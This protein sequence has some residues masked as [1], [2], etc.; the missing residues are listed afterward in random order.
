MGI[1]LCSGRGTGKSRALARSIAWQDWLS[2]VPVVIIDG[3]GRCCEE[4]IDRLLYL[5]PEY[6]VSLAKRIRYVDCSGQSGYVT[7]T[8]LWYRIGSESLREVSQRF[9]ALILKTDPSLI[10]ASVEGF[11]ALNRIATYTGMVLFAMGCQ[12]TEAD[13]FLRN[14]EAWSSH[15]PEAVRTYP[16]VAPAVE[17]FTQ[18]YREMQPRSRE[19]LTEAFRNKIFALSLDPA[20]QALFGAAAPGIDWP[21]VVAERQAVLLDF[22]RA[23]S[24]MQQLFMLWWFDYLYAYIKQRGPGKNNVPLSFLIDELVLLTNPK[25]TGVNPFEADLDELIQVYS[26]NASVWL[27]VAHQEYHQLN[28][29]LRHTMASLGTQV[30]GRVSDID[31]ALALAKEL[32]KADPWKVKW[33]ENVWASDSTNRLETLHFV[34]DS[35]AVNMSIDEQILLQAYALKELN[36]FE[37]LVRPATVEGGVSRKVFRVRM[38]VDKGL[39]VNEKLVSQARDVLLRRHGIPVEHILTEVKG[40]LHGER[41]RYPPEEPSIPRVP[42]ARDNEPVD[43]LATM[44]EYG[45]P[46]PSSFSPE[47]EEDDEYELLR[48]PRAQAQASPAQSRNE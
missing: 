29:R 9:P 12:I 13:A 5:P 44:R 11:N 45:D 10:S 30:I 24:T 34:I 1:R 15:F 36:P 17:F 48:E 16:E 23:P 46:L 4:F 18:E 42:N 31:S 14:P 39:W 6:Q 47:E 33:Y 21:T 38:N 2:G 7:P 40:R 27:T 32:F 26:R 8:P 25:V 3:V 37:F 22:S 35:R 28:E 20:L 41:P 43:T 19:R